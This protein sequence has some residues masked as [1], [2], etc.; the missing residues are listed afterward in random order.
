M[1]F[2]RE[3]IRKE[4]TANR[5]EIE[6]AAY[7]DDQLTEWADGFVPV[8][9]SDIIRDWVEL[10]IEDSDKWKD[11]GYDANKNDGGIIELMKIDLWFHYQDTTSLIWREITGENE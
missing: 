8:Y 1:Y 2:T 6:S 4:L 10:P 3:E 9:N 11:Y 5:E 7:P